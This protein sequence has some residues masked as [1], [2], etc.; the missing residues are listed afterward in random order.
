M[1]VSTFGVTAAIVTAEYLARYTTSTSSPLTTANLGEIITSAAAHINGLLAQA[2]VTDASVID[3]TGEP[4]L[5][6][7]CRD[8]VCMETAVRAWRSISPGDQGLAEA[9]KTDLDRMIADLLHNPS[10]FLAELYSADSHSRVRSHITGIPA[11]DADEDAGGENDDVTPVVRRD[12]G[13]MG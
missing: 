1:A 12:D 3:S 4:I 11:T 7:R 5:Y 2:G 9:W 6:R 13:D 10:G 8:M